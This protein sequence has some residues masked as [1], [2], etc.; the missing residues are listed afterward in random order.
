MKK[1]TNHLCTLTLSRQIIRTL[2]ADELR[3]VDGGS[4]TSFCTTGTATGAGSNNSC[5]TGTCRQN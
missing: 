5:G 4:F 2:G 3:A 1:K